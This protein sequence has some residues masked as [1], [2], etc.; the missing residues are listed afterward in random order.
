MHK[1]AIWSSSS[2][3]EITFPEAGTYKIVTYCRDAVGEKGVIYQ[4]LTVE[5]SVVKPSGISL[6]ANTLEIDKGQTATLTATVTP[7]DAANKTVTWSSS[8]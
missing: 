3:E 1:S 4:T 8:D 5:Q 6:S 7:A 2:A